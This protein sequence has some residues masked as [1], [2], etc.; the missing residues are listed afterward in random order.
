MDNTSPQTTSCNRQY[1]RSI[2]GRGFEI[3]DTII[4]FFVLT[5]HILNLYLLVFS[6]GEGYSYVLG[7]KVP[8]SGFDKPKA[9]SL[10]KGTNI[11]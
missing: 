5:K 7:P 11:T 6:Q 8:S 3:E 1:E 10:N 2:K 9:Y 4:K